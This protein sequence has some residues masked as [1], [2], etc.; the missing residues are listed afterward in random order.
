MSY[1]KYILRIIFVCVYLTSCSVSNL[2]LD[3]VRPAEIDV[4]T[5]IK[6]VVIINRSLPSKQ[7]QAENILDGLFSGEGVGDDKK[8]AEMCV[9]TLHQNLLNAPST[10]SRF[11]V[12]ESDGLLH[13]DQ[14]LGTGTADFPK[15]IKWKKINK[16]SK[17]YDLDGLIVLETFDSE[18]SIINGGVVEKIKK[19]NGEKIKQKFIEAYLNIQVQAGWRIYDIVNKKIIDEK[20]FTDFKEF[21]AL[22]NNFE[23]A[24]NKLPSKRSA[25]SSTG[26]F[27]GEQYAIRISP[28]REKVHRSYYI[29]ADRGA[30]EVN[31]SFKK[32]SDLLKRNL[33]K[34]ATSIWANFVDHENYQIASRACFNMAL[35][36]ELKNNYNL[37]IEWIE[38]SIYYNSSNKKTIDYLQILKI[39]QQEINR[40]TNQLNN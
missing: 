8:G 26:S 25:I 32:A 37:A 5:N 29:K 13:G 22:G 17:N 31:Q 20:V 24:K 11:N 39:R 9:R 18:S 36:A 16:L 1:I 23:E 21:S 27:A 7:N 38:K 34:N 28:N 30:K 4:S 15:P 33:I 10:I 40:V 3:V 12:I 35:A 6:N 19:I 14:F 2:S